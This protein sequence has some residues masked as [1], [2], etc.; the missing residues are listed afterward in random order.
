MQHFS[1]HPADTKPKI[2]DWAA[3][4]HRR[5]QARAA[6]DVVVWTNGCFDVLHVG[7]IRCLQAARTFGDLL[8]VGLNSDESIRQLKGPDRPIMPATERAEILGSLACVDYVVVFEEPT[9][10]ASIAR[11]KPDVHCKGADYAPPD[12]KPLPERA[13]VE[14]YGGRIEFIPLVPSMSTSDVI[15]RIRQ[16]EG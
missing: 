8:V 13:I 10:E 7:H 1:P 11:L 14:G 2:V 5:E 6:G 16:E 4:L 9:P 3:L 12:G 15:C